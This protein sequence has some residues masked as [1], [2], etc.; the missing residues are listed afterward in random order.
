VSAARAQRVDLANCLG[1]LLDNEL[2][3]VHNW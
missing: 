2:G 1:R 3:R